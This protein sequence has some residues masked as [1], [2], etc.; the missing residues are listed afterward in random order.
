MTVL[1]YLFW[2]FALL[3][4]VGGVVAA[5]LAIRLRRRP[6]A[7]LS[8]VPVAG[9]LLL[10][11]FGID[12]LPEPHGFGVTLAI[13]IAAIG[14]IGGNPLTAQV[15]DAATRGTV[16]GGAHGGILIAHDGSEEPR[17]VL[18]GGTTIGYLERLA[19]IGSVAVGHPEVVVALI[20]VKGLGR[21]SELDSATARERFIIGTL[22]SMIW[23]GAC[24]VLAVVTAA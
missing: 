23:A 7:L 20:A 15:L 11:A 6:L 22:A 2:A 13:G 9:G 4:I 17:E 1:S 10:A 12:P 14:V 21:F 3:V 5:A 18:R 24:A 19:I 8:I 16:A